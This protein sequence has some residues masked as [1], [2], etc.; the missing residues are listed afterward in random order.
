MILIFGTWAVFGTRSGVLN[1]KKS[2]SC[3]ESIDPL[4]FAPIAIRLAVSVV[5]FGSR[6]S[7]VVPGR[8][9]ETFEKPKGILITSPLLAGKNRGSTKIAQPAR[10]TARAGVENWNFWR[11]IVIEF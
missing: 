9:S 8:G 5:S 1:L 11:K 7:E 6:S 4:T 2:L 3:S 10:K